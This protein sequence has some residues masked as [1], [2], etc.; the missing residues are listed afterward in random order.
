MDRESL[1]RF[2]R[3]IICGNFARQIAVKLGGRIF[4]QPCDKPAADDF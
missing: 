1:A 2:R 3:W 4:D